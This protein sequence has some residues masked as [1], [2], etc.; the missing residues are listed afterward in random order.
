[1]PPSR[2]PGLSAL[3]VAGAL[4]LLV[5]IL[6]GQ[7]LG[8]RALLQSEQRMPVAGLNITPVPQPSPTDPG[9]L[10][11]WKRLQVTAV[12]TDPA[13]PDPRVTHTPAP[14]PKPTPTPKP[15][16]RPTVTVPPAYTSPPLPLP[17]A[18][19][20]PDENTPEPSDTPVNGAVPP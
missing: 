4:V 7:K 17:I 11:D 2:R 19:H 16:P 15:S 5:S 10:H 1:M 12:A 18:S 14:T 9:N 20:E 3:L 6:I 8:N 13:F